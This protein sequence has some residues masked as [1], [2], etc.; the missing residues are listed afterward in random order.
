M[1]IRR[2]SIILLISAIVIAA[3]IMLFFVLTGEREKIDWLGFGF[4]LTAELVMTIGLLLLEGMESQ[5]TG[6]LLRAGIYST[7]GLYAVI[8][9]VTSVLFI[10]FFRVNGN[11]LTA[12][13][14]VLLALAMIVII[15]IHFANA[16]VSESNEA[17]LQSAGRMQLLLSRVTV[18]QGRNEAAVLK[19]Q[20]DKLY[21]AL[22]YCDVS[23]AVPTDDLVAARLGELEMLIGNDREEQ[24]ENAAR[25]INDILALMKQRSAEMSLVKAGGI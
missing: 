5:S 16:H 19:P 24:A 12:I 23:V 22:R 2:L 20:L 21:E 4:L 10:L 14:I 7:L 17:V 11:Y 3:T 15:I 8:S 6:V 1:K 18:L 25:L 9:I 13:Q